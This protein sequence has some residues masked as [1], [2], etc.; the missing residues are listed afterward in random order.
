M[1]PYLLIQYN[2]VAYVFA[3][4]KKKK[5]G[6]SVMEVG[7]HKLVPMQINIVQLKTK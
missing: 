1:S 5:E 4:S 2:L 3:Q 7:K 6:G